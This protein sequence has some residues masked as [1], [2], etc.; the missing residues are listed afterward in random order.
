MVRETS[1][2]VRPAEFSE[3]MRMDSTRSTVRPALHVALRL[4]LAVALALGTPGCSDDPPAVPSRPN[5]LLISIDSLRADHLRCYGYERETS[6]VLDRLAAEGA[7]FSTVVSP[8]T[9][10]LPAHATLFTGLPPEGH[11]LRSDATALSP[12]AVCLA[13]IFADADYATAAFVGGPFL[14]SMYGFDQGF[15][16]YDDQTVMRPL[17]DSHKGATS[18]ELVGLTTRWL[19]GWDARAE[20]GPFFVF[21]HLWDV[22]FDYTP[23]PPY[24]TMFDP[25]YAGDIT[26]EDFEL[27]SQIHR[28]MDERDLAHVVALYDGEIRFTD[29][30]VGRLL[31]HLESLGQLDE[32]IV[33]VTSDHG[34]EF[35]DHGWKG[36]R[37][38]LYDETLLVPLL[39]RHP[40]T[41]AAGRV[42]DEQVRLMDVPATVASLAGLPLPSGFGAR[43]GPPS[44]SPADLSPLITNSTGDS[45]AAATGAATGGD[46]ERLAFSDLHGT[47]ASV[48]TGTH[49]LVH[50]PGGRARELLFD[51]MADPLEQANLENSTPERESLR[52]RL[53]EWKRFWGPR[54][55][56]SVDIEL[57]DEQME[58][59]RALG[60]IR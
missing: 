38:N 22:H 31:A 4:S 8:T 34:E 9:W 18:P 45:T 33:V 2:E 14:R 15:D 43:G 24:D 54:R 56:P 16:T 40:E 35:F 59:L 1:M 11:G 50:R 3:I 20:D 23:P 41:V 44:T 57:S 52:S 48:R 13:E 46:L 6:P 19:D 36:H 29:E 26:G 53:D 10:T 7:R 55:P 39:I 47:W 27:G 51:L 58:S 12:A 60:Y 49:K 17:L 30:W 5:V 21:L 37:K 32:T 28:D 42:V 25:H